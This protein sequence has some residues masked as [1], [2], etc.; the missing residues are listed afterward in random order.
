MRLCLVSPTIVRIVNTVL[1]S[2]AARVLSFA[3]PDHQSLIHS[4][5][6]TYQV[7]CI[8]PNLQVSPIRAPQLPGV[9]VRQWPSVK[10][11]VCTR[12]QNTDHRPRL[13][14]KYH[15]DAEKSKCTCRGRVA[16][17]CGA[18]A[19]AGLRVD[20]RDTWLVARLLPHEVY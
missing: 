9:L 19:S 8:C 2:A 12:N 10:L 15:Y 7:Y 16:I 20:A 11:S 6:L 5:H 14:R 18:G 13:R 17:C 1:L 3:S 4:I